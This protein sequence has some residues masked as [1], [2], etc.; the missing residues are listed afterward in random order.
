MKER[1]IAGIDLGSA[2]I[3]LAVGQVLLGAD[4]RENLNI[5][6]AVE[7]PSQGISK[8]V[9]NSLEDAVST[10]SMCLEQAERQIGLPVSEAYVG[11]TG[12]FTNVQ[13]ARG[14]IGVS[15][16]DGEIR[17]EDVHRV[18]ES[19]RSVVN[20]VNYEILHVLPR[21]FTVDG[22]TGIKDPVGMQGI[23]LEA[24]AHIVQGLASPVRNLTKAVFR[25]GLDITELVFAPLA[26]AEAVTTPR[27]RDLG[28]AVVNIG[29]TTTAMTV[30]EDGDLLHAAIL[31]VGSDHITADIAIVLRTSLDVAERFKQS[32]SS[33]L[34]EHMD[35]YQE[36]DL[37]ELGAD[38]SELISPRFVSDIVRARVEEIF[39]MVEGELKKIERSG[40]L[41]AGVILTGG[42]VRLRGLSD[43]G[44]RV[45]RL[46]VSVSTASQIPTPLL[47]I[48][49]DPAFSTVLGLV[50]WGY[51]NERASGGTMNRAVSG[52]RKGG[53]FM[54]KI[55]APLKKI[56][57]S[58][59]P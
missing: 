6:G 35:Q 51:E 36:V 43:V 9:V 34:P 15:R 22:Q 13:L 16:V 27:Q 46:P 21:G 45:L 55:G 25:T 50:H 52:R 7:I 54:Q 17:E 59:I 12:A 30:Y 38:T 20:P 47:E 14:V 31:P 48:A 10:L 49:Q 4:K 28:V 32:L 19:A 2:Y 41:P 39:E 29:A 40:M 24:D 11:V 18:L 23:R 5:I 44:K 1:L 53:D 26:T 42:G 8:G 3:R 33:A 58:F 37:Q 57:K 56:F